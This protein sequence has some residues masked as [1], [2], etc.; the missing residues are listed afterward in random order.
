MTACT[1]AGVAGHEHGPS[2]GQLIV[3]EILPLLVGVVRRRCE[4]HVHVVAVVVL[5]SG[6][7]V[8][9]RCSRGRAVAHLYGA[10]HVVH[11][12]RHGVL[13]GLRRRVGVGVCHVVP[14]EGHARQ[15]RVRSGGVVPSRGVAGY[16]GALLLRPLPEIHHL[17]HGGGHASRGRQHVVAVVVVLGALLVVG[18]ALVPAARNE[19]G[20]EVLGGRPCGRGGHGTGS[21]LRTLYGAVVGGGHHLRQLVE[22][23]PQLV[24]HVVGIYAAAVGVAQHL[25][26]A[27]ARRHEHET[28]ALT[29]VEEVVRWILDGHG[30]LAR[31]GRRG[32]ALSTRDTRGEERLCL[33]ACLLLAY[34]ARTDECGQQQRGGT[35]DD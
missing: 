31:D 16:A 22:P 28:V 8:A 3:D 6:D 1:V 19:R 9:R 10:A 29:H 4:V 23:C 21:A 24:G 27:V 18:V 14:V 13:A 17:R 5:E 35:E 32:P 33:T 11:E 15:C 26:C 12:L 30:E 2:C 25:A 20:N 34:R 7:T